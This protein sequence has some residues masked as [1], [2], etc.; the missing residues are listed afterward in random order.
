[1][2]NININL[3][4]PCGMN[5]AGCMAYLR[6]KNHCPGCNLGPTN[7]ACC[8][9]T[10]KLCT[11]RKGKYCSTCTQDGPCK[12][13]KQLDKRYR[14][15]YHMSMLENLANIKDLGI[16]QFVKNEKTRWTCSKCGG[17]ICIHGHYCIDCEKKK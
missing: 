16:R 14:E 10:I 9:C 3:I 1:M 2:K 13:L 6:V 11:K 17:T 12:R 5:C 8:N 4:A 7:K 15:K